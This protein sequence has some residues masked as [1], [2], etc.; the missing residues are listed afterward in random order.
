MCY[1][2]THVQTG[3][4]KLL[5]IVNCSILHNEIALSNTLLGKKG[6]EEEKWEWTRKNKKEQE[7]TR[8]SNKEQERTRKKKKNK[9]EQIRKRDNEKKKL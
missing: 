2:P 4:Y 5:D 8:M 9:K 6:W 1:L 3:S 7:G